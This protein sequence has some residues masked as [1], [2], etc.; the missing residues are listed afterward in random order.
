MFEP[1]GIVIEKPLMKP[2]LR[3]IPDRAVMQ[4]IVNRYILLKNDK[5]MW[6]EDS[7]F[8]GLPKF[9]KTI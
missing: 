2:V 9:K 1:P 5:K 3:Y 8:V 7:K 4:R 6:S